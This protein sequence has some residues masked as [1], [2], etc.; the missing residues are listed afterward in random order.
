MG[1]VENI[2]VDGQGADGESARSIRFPKSI[3][4]AI[5][6]DAKAHRRSAVKQMEQIFAIYYEL[7]YAE[8][9]RDTLAEARSRVNLDVN[10]KDAERERAVANRQT[11]KTH[12]SIPEQ[13]KKDKIIKARQ[14][15]SPEE[16]GGTMSEG[17]NERDKR[18]HR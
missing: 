8:I 1:N 11:T 10:K 9:N 4:K 17:E 18:I 7:R 12:G 14:T 13:R 16:R 6:A 15:S 3:W 2:G 5:D